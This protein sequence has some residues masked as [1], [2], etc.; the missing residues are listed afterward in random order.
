MPGWRGVEV[1]R[2]VMARFMANSRHEIKGLHHFF[3][4]R[5]AIRA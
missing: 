4:R 3:G 5:C 2:F 1:Q